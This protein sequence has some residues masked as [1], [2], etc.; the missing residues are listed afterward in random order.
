VKY[1]FSKIID[2]N[3]NVLELGAGYCDFINNVKAKKK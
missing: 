2:L 1:Y 3:A